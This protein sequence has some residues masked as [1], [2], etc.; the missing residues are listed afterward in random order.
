M[1]DK[2]PNL[3]PTTDD[4]AIR[5][6]PGGHGRR[7]VLQY[8]NDLLWVGESGKPSYTTEDLE[9]IVRNPKAPPSKMLAARRI[10]SACRDPTRYVK[11]K[12]G[13]VFPAGSDPEPGR[14][15]DRIVDRLEGKPTVRIEH[16][17]GPRRSENEV[18]TELLKLVTKHPELM[19]IMQNRIVGDT[20]AN[21]PDGDNENDLS[22]ES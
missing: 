21:E 19:S 14:D 10:L 16:E 13:N 17:D 7:S 18:R 4:S 6:M 8:L 15:F 12:H 22:L 2:Y 5:S 3:K 11:D 9:A 1:T 20:D